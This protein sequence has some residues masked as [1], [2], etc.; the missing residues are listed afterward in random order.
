MRPHL[1]TIVLLDSL[2]GAHE[3]VLAAVRAWVRDEF[4]HRRQQAVDACAWRVERVTAQTPRQTDGGSCGVFV[5]MYAWY[6]MMFGRLPTIS[7]FTNADH[8]ELRCFI[9]SAILRPDAVYPA[10]VVRAARAVAAA[11]VVE[12]VDLAAEEEGVPN[13]GSEEAAQLRRELDAP[14]VVGREGKAPL[15]RPRE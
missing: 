1:Q 13:P 10:G 15:R 6:W 9:T 12:V 4:A 11:A 7:D 14:P 3:E 8:E 2:G 5:S